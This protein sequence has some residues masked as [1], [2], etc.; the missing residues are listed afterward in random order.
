M[1]RDVLALLPLRVKKMCVCG[2]V[3]LMQP[4]VGRVSV[5]EKNI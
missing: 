5:A 4:V 1:Y 3:A 2:C